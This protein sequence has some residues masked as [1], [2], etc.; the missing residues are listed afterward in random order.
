MAKKVKLVPLPDEIWVT[1]FHTYSVVGSICH[2]SS[3]EKFFRTKEE[4]QHEIDTMQGW[5][6]MGD[7]KQYR[8][9]KLISSEKSDE[10]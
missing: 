8:P 5:I 2:I 3:G 4:C 9:V 1:G 7:R 10:S 6:G